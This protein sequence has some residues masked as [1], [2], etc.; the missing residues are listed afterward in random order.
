MQTDLIKSINRA[1]KNAGLPLRIP[2]SLDGSLT[3]TVERADLVV[4]EGYPVVC[5]RDGDRSPRLEL[6]KREI[7]S[8]YPRGAFRGPAD[9]ELYRVDVRNSGAGVLLVQL[10]I[11]R[12]TTHPIDLRIDLEPSSTISSLPNV[13]TA[14][15]HNTVNYFVCYAQKDLLAGV[16]SES[17][18][19]WLSRS[20][21]YRFEGWR[22]TELLPGHDWNSIIQEQLEKCDMAVL[23]ISP[24]FLASNYI[25][26]HELPK[27]HDKIVIPVYLYP[28]DPEVHNLRD[29]KKVTIFG[30]RERAYSDVSPEQRGSFF[31]K[32]IDA[33]ERRMQE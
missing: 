18:K 3:A 22:D 29:L 17:L 10:F 32:L 21:N 20:S 1:L 7:V 19:L 28:V 31:A 27:L 26:E 30:Y 33:I 8:Y 6:D 4:I 23:L 5:N 16:F 25:N 13:K 9:D 12:S 15:R 2:R 14:V 24:N 11:D